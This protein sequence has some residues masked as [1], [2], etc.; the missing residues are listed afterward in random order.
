M[1]INTT[2]LCNIPVIA[3]ADTGAYSDKYSLERELGS[4][5][6]GTVWSAK[7]LC[8][9]AS[10]AIKFIKR[11]KIAP[12]CWTTDPELGPCP[13]EVFVLKNVSFVNT[14]R[15]SEYYILY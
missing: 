9:G 2:N 11:S 10:V 6:F 14:D 15:S 4:G 1:L 13:L 12:K 3:K 8:D 7:R 5:G